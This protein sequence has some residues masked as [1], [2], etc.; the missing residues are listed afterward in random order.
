MKL[1]KSPR[2]SALERGEDLRG[3]GNLRADLELLGF[4]KEVVAG[5]LTNLEKIC[6]LF[7]VSSGTLNR[8]PAVGYGVQLIENTLDE[9][10]KAR[11]PHLVLPEIPADVSNFHRR[12]MY[13]A[14]VRGSG[15]ERSR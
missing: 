5:F 7:G 11:R 2:D 12:T 6:A 15:P 8:L 9:I 4:K 13:H 3:S 1:L 14:E 10:M